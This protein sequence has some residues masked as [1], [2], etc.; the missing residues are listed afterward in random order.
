[1]PLAIARQV[2]ARFAECELT[3]IQREPIDIAKARAQHAEYVRALQELGCH[4]VELPAE[5]DLPD[6]VFVEDAAF[7]LPE[8]AVITRPGADSRKPETV[9]VA[10]A[11]RPHRDLIFVRE[12]ATIDGGDV[13]VLERDIYVGLSSR[14]NAAAIQQLQAMLGRHGYCVHGVEV[15]KFLHLKSAVTRL[16]EGTLLLNPAWIDASLFGKF[17]H[18]EVAPSEPMAANILVINGTGIYPTSF[19]ETQARIE[20]HGTQLVTLDVS[21]IAKAEGA[22]TCCSLILQ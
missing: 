7:I 4:V 1:M 15:D 19:P 13:L 14:T 11:L 16:D 21:E 22:V 3:H 10:D 18:V 8:V 9:S 6:S 20:A 2:S 17:E 5:D 12:P